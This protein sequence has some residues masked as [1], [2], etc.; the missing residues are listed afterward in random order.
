[1]RKIPIND[2]TEPYRR[3]RVR[4]LAAEATGSRSELEARY[5]RTWTTAELRQDF[6]VLGFMAPFRA[7]ESERQERKS[8]IPA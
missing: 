2:E 5:G 1:M 3:A 6:E 7:R 8:G 4:E